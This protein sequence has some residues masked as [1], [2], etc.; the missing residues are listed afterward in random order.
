MA[1]L[2]WLVGIEGKANRKVGVDT[3]ESKLL[4]SMA[5]VDK[6]GENID[7]RDVDNQDSQ[8]ESGADKKRGSGLRSSEVPVK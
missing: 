7:D 3:L 1:H 8:R 5:A 4:S 2:K 6:F